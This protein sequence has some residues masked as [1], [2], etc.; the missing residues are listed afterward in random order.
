[1]AAGLKVGDHVSV[2]SIHLVEKRNPDMVRYVGKSGFI[3]R[4]LPAEWDFPRAFRI[5]FGDDLPPL[6][7]FAKELERLA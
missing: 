6:A 1:M 5:D 3:I 4:I 2:L 7:F